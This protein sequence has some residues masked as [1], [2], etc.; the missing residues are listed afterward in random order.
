MAA[1]RSQSEEQLQYRPAHHFLAGGVALNCVA[2]AKILEHTDVRRLWV[3]PCASD[4]GAPLG[5]ALWHYHHDLGHARGFELKHA[6]LGK[7]YREE[8]IACALDAAGLGY[9]HALGW[10][11]ADALDDVASVGDALYGCYRRLLAALDEVL[12]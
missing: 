11:G 8:E 3:P 2:N 7:A 9:H 5:S 1:R 12:A 10:I 4:T 6:L